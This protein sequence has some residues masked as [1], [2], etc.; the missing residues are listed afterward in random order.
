MSAALVIQHA[1]GMRHIVA[2]ACPAVQYFFPHMAVLLYSQ[3]VRYVNYSSLL[4]ETKIY[5]TAFLV[6]YI[7]I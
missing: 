3:C 2:V 4:K 5:K 1:M 6:Y 7:I